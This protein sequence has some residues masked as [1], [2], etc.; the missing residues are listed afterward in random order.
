MFSV[1]LVLIIQVSG[2]PHLPYPSQKPLFSKPGTPVNGRRPSWFHRHSTAN[3]P[4]C[5][6]CP[7]LL[8]PP[9]AP[10]GTRETLVRAWMILVSEVWSKQKLE[11]HGKALWIWNILKHVLL[12]PSR[13]LG[14]VW[15][16][17]ARLMLLDHFI[18]GFRSI[19]WKT[20]SVTACLWLWLEEFHPCQ[21]GPA[22]CCVLFIR[23]CSL[24]LLLSHLA[25]DRCMEA[26]G[27][28]RRMPLLASYLSSYLS[29]S[30]HTV[31]TSVTSGQFFTVVPRSG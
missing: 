13:D 23:Q 10:T 15:K 2:Y 6:C 29:W 21:C 28:S 7:L 9:D 4:T 25:G 30:R 19:L 1:C 3:R 26:I 14:L 27:K 24:A 16:L 22:W 18:H 31:A 11:K 8:S 17:H 20:E 5:R 12:Q